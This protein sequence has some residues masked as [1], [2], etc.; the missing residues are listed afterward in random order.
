MVVGVV[1]GDS[2]DSGD[3]SANDDGGDSLG[4][5]V[6][7]LGRG[8]GDGS[9]D[10]RGSVDDSGDESGVG[11]E[12]VVVSRGSGGRGVD[13]GE[14]VNSS[15]DK[16]EIVNSVNK[17]ESVNKIIVNKG[18]VNKEIV[19]EGDVVEGSV[20]G[21]DAIDLA[22]GGHKFT[23]N[24]KGDKM[25]IPGRDFYDGMDVV[26]L[27]KLEKIKL[28][29]HIENCK[30]KI[31]RSL[32]S[33]FGSVNSMDMYVEPGTEKVRYTFRCPIEVCVCLCLCC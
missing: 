23:Q 10:Q 28:S 29:S 7:S 19:N 9:G 5:L 25:Y 21:G 27:D 26:K 24:Y 2:G 11:G 22:P 12:G 16:G 13:K 4:R 6:R 30:R 8:V 31:Q 1:G 3:D 17:C 33:M 20:V 15:V 14:I 32:G 18:I